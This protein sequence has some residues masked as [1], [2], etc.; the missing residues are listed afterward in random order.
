MAIDGV[1]GG[2]SGEV[3]AGLGVGIVVSAVLIA[4]ILY[5]ARKWER[6]KPKSN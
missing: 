1:V 2:H 3:V 5:F 6:R 4:A